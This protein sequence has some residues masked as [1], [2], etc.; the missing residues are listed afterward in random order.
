MKVPKQEHYSAHKGRI[1]VNGGHGLL[2]RGNRKRTLQVLD[3]IVDVLYSDGYADKVG[4]KRKRLL[5]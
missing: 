3:Q 5:Q 1:L 4:W 2:P